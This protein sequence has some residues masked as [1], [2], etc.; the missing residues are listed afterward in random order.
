VKNALINIGII[1]CMSLAVF[2]VGMMVIMGIVTTVE[3]IL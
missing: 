3:W 1:F 2:I